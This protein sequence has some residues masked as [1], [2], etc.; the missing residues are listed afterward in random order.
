[1]EASREE[2]W[3]NALME[4]NVLNSIWSEFIQSQVFGDQETDYEMP[5]LNEGSVCIIL[6]Y[7]LL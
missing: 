4:Y 5:L 3:R 6:L 1:M 7:G 2:K